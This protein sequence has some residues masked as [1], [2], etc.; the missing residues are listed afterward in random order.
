MVF[1]ACVTSG[2]VLSMF[3]HVVARRLFPQL[4]P[5]LEE[6]QTEGLTLTNVHGINGPYKIKIQDVLV[7]LLEHQ[8]GQGAKVQLQRAD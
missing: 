2:L 3:G 7:R 5:T 8:A 1:P 6:A 4:E